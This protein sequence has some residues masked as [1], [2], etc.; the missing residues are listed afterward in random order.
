MEYNMLCKIISNKN[1]VEFSRKIMIWR[2]IEQQDSKK[3]YPSLNNKIRKKISVNINVNVV[4]SSPAWLQNII[5]KVQK[6]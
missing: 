3:K 6:T 5:Q 2:F 4:L 1:M